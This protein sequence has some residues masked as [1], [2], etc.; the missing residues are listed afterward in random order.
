M[1]LSVYFIRLNTGNNGEKWL[2]HKSNI[3]HHALSA[4]GKEVAEKLRMGTDNSS[5][6]I[7]IELSP[8]LD[9]I[10]GLGRWQKYLLIYI[11]FQ[12]PLV[13]QSAELHVRV[14]FNTTMKP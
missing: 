13:K 12:I 6:P 7:I 8:V 3:V 11:S 4:V 14:L 2:L 9:G 5:D 1:G 10:N